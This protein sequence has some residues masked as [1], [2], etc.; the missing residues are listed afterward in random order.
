MKILMIILTLEIDM[1]D[2]QNMIAR[3]NALLSK[4]V[5]NG[6]T[7]A[8]AMLAVEKATQLMTKYQLSLSELELR[9]KGAII[10]KLNFKNPMQVFAAW[11]LMN[12]INLVCEV[13]SFRQGKEDYFIVGLEEDVKFAEWLFKNLVEFG[14]NAVQTWWKSPEVFVE[15]SMAV[16]RQK[17]KLSYLVGFAVRISSR[18]MEISSAR[19]MQKQQH[20]T[21]NALVPISSIKKEKINDL[22]KQNGINLRNIVDRQKSF[23]KEAKMAGYKKGDEASLARISGELK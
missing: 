20:S 17:L 12:S 7:E 3:I 14:Y 18:A 16:N 19:I 13:T 4:T 10:K 22:F 8:E 23:D 5:E 9:E 6:A 1:E 15:S 21:S 2:K 11:N